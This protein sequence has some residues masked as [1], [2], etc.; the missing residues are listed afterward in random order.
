MTNGKTG[1]ELANW[2]EALEEK[3]KQSNRYYKGE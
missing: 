1:F 2:E 3:K